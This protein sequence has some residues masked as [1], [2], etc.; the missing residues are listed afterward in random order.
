MNGSFRGRQSVEGVKL[1][2]RRNL[3]SSFSS[4][5]DAL[6]KLKIKLFICDISLKNGENTNT[7]RII[8]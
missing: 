8:E 3:S 5:N 2:G 1:L 4:A 6:Y 7:H